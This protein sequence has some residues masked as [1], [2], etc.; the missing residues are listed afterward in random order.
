MTAYK[1]NARILKDGLLALLSS[2][3]YDAGNGEGS[4]F[5]LV[6]DDP[7]GAITAE[8]YALVIPAPWEDIKGPVG[9]NDRTVC[10]TIV[11]LLSLEDKQR[12]QPQSYNMM[13]DLTELVLDA[14]DESDFTDG[15]NQYNPDPKNW[16]LESPKAHILPAEWK[17]GGAVLLC[18]I[19][20]A[21][22]YTKDL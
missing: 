5:E 16:I 20:V 14:L 6:T 15:L 22:K 19:D 7:S 1:S 2:I 9:Q 4:A 18:R 8:P 13:E 17:K 11:M 3:Q 10:F 12:T 21:I